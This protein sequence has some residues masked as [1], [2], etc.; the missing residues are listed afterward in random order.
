MR[1]LNPLFKYL[2]VLKHNQELHFPNC[3]ALILSI[4]PTIVGSI[5][6]WLKPLEDGVCKHPSK[7]VQKTYEKKLFVICIWVVNLYVEL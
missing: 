5:K 7:P 2:A 3:Y 4:F 1:S 6:M